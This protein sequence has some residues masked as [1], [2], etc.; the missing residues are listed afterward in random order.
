MTFNRILRCSVV[1][2]RPDGAGRLLLHDN[3]MDRM[4]LTRRGGCRRRTWR[5][6]RCHG[7]GGNRLC[8]PPYVESA[9]KRPGIVTRPV[10][11]DGYSAVGWV[12]GVDGY[13]LA[14]THSGITL[15]AHLGAVIAAEIE[16]GVGDEA[17]VPF[18]PAR[19]FAGNAG[20]VGG[21]EALT[22]AG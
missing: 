4:S 6:L 11:A 14:V 7:G 3:A 15:S 9:P 13:Y 5:R 1:D 16:G 2:L 8:S 22:H 12:P 10:P 21:A 19:F 17:M 20:I 18:R